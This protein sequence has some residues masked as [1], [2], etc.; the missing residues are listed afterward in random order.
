MFVS[1]RRKSSSAL[2]RIMYYQHVSLYRHNTSL[3]ATYCIAMHTLA[4]CASTLHWSCWCM[5][6][7][8]W[9]LQCLSAITP[10]DFFVLYQF[11]V[12]LFLCIL[13]LLW[14]SPWSRDAICSPQ[15][16]QETGGAQ[17][18]QTKEKGLHHFNNVMAAVK[19]WQPWQLQLL[20][21]A[22]LSCRSQQVFLWPS[23]FDARG[24]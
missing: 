10:P 17:Q 20:R 3:V 18:H 11:H 21:F 6:Y 9:L 12:V 1:W 19:P 14:I 15:P 8:I 24:W 5:L 2:S 4:S 13:S 16:L 22:M 7:P 23:C